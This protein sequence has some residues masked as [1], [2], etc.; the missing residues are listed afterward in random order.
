[1]QIIDME[2]F[3]MLTWQ[4]GRAPR[5]TMRLHN[6]KEYTCVC[7]AVH[8][9]HHSRV[10]RELPRRHVVI[11]CEHKHGLACLQVKG[12]LFTRLSMRFG[13]LR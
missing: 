4:R 11:E 13:A 9:F 1:M 6:G 7:G 3:F 12:L 10:T 5:R 2:E 8:R